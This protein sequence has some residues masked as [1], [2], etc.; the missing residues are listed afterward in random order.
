M[1]ASRDASMLPPEITQQMVPPPTLP[2]SA[3]ASDSA[4][5]PSATIRIRSTS[6]ESIHDFDLDGEVAA[7]VRELDRA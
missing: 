1:A 5:A 4:P 7:S 3:A 6:Q 2:D